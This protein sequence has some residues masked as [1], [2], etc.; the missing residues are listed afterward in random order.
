MDR[1]LA[2]F[3]MSPSFAGAIFVSFFSLVTTVTL[4]ITFIFHMPIWLLT[5][6][7]FLTPVS[8]FAVYYIVDT[9][10]LKGHKKTQIFVAVFLSVIIITFTAF[11][12]DGAFHMDVQTP[13]TTWQEGLKN[14]FLPGMTSREWFVT[15][16]HVLLDFYVSNMLLCNIFVVI[17]PMVVI[18]CAILCHKRERKKLVSI[19]DV[20]SFNRYQ[21][22][23]AAEKQLEEKTLL[24]ILNEVDEELYESQLSDNVFVHNA[25][26]LEEE[27]I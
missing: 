17:I 16:T 9:L 5:F 2:S 8:V 15:L 18:V 3:K 1:T 22:M 4:M 26:K 24:D 6:A 10:I 27:E 20:Q 14:I 25:N 11:L 21:N 19:A 7:I 12:W 13:A 23:I